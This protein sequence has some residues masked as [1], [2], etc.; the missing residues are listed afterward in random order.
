MITS[1]A[2]GGDRGHQEAEAE[3]G[4]GGRGGQADEDRTLRRAQQTL[5]EQRK[6]SER[7]HRV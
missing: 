1:A 2:G 7:N 3:G 4:R 5:Q 6:L